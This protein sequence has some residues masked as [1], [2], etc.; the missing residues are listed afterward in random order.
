MRKKINVVDF[1]YHHPTEVVYFFY[2]EDFYKITFTVY[3]LHNKRFAEIIQK[4][5]EN[6]DKAEL[7]KTK[8]EILREWKRRK[9]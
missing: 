1:E 5:K 9:K 4:I 3:D 8:A 7:I 2:G 6:M